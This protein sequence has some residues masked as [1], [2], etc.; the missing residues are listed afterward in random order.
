MG[1]AIDATCWFHIRPMLEGRYAGVAYAVLDSNSPV[2]IRHRGELDEPTML[3]IAA[4]FPE[5]IRVE[6]Q[7]V[8]WEGE[9]TSLLERILMVDYLQML[10]KQ[11]AE[12]IAMMTQTRKAEDG[13]Q[14]DD[15]RQ[16]VR[17]FFQAHDTLQEHD[18]SWKKPGEKS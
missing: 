17:E 2:I 4:L 13:I 18:Q 8:Y 10:Y 11:N 1:F 15:A 6:F 12:Q 3:K 16:E 5:Q 9:K 7:Q 14:G